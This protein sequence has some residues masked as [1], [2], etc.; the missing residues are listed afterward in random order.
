LPP[1]HAFGGTPA[2][3]FGMVVCA[4]AAGIVTPVVIG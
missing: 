2:Q 1:H 3:G 4:G